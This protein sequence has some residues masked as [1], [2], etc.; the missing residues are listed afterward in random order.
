MLLAI[1][2]GAVTKGIWRPRAVVAQDATE[3]QLGVILSASQ[4]VPP[5]S[6]ATTAQG[7]GTITVNVDRTVISY[8][9]TLTGPFT[10]VPLQAHIHAG[11]PGMS[12]PILFFLCATDSAVPAAAPVGVQAC[13]DASGG[14]LS[15]TLTEAEFIPQPEAGIDTFADAVAALSSGNAYVNIH[16]PA[17]LAGEIR[18][19]I[20]AVGLGAILTSAAEIPPVTTATLATGTATLTIN[21]EHTEVAYSLTLTGPF[22]GD[23]LQIH[24]NAGAVAGTGPVLFFLCATD[25]AVP[26]AAPV[27]VPLCPTAAGGTVSGILTEVDLIPQP[28]AGIVTFADAVA[29]LMSS[30]VYMNVST[31]ANPSGEIRGQIGVALHADLTSA[32]AVPP[33]VAPTVATGEALLVFNQE[34]SQIAYV[35]TLAGPLTGDPLQ[36]HLNAGAADSAGPILFFLCATDPAVPAAAPVGVQVCPTAAGGTVSGVLTEADLVAQPD[37]GIVT[38]ADA[39]AALVSNGTYIN[40]HTPANPTGEIRGQIELVQPLPEPVVSFSL[41]IQPI[42]N[43]NCS[44]HLLVPPA[45]G[46]SLQE[47][48]SFAN[49]AGVPSGQRPDLQ[50]VAPGDPDNSY[51]FMKHS[52]APGILNSRMPLT[53]PTFFDRNPDLLELERQWILAG[54]PNN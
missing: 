36:M 37:I 43:A 45:A 15:G 22:T 13:P 14:V 49:L 8:T 1:A 50:R 18:G 12:G 9:F 31:V 17:N 27:G 2:F 54:A 28:D 11:S 48:V 38:F 42:F 51:L 33:V 29:A 4:E 3:V 44:C 26:A 20:G 32:A 41:Q 19:Q 23:P 24:L 7:L 6:V 40:L 53:D 10:D 34:Q 46:L 35:V 25:P 39:V 52:G 16:T 21:P 47:G 30:G 5:V